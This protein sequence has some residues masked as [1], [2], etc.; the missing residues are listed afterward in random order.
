MPNGPALFEMLWACFWA[1]LVAERF[2]RYV[3]AL[4]PV[5]NGAWNVFSSAAASR[6]MAGASVPD[7][8][9]MMIITR[10]TDPCL[11]RRTIFR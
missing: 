9:A 3:D 1:G 2:L 4:A 10:R 5:L 11:P 7:A 8:D 6:A